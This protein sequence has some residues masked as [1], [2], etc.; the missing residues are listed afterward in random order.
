MSSQQNSFTKWIAVSVAILAVLGLASLWRWTP[1][2]EWASSGQLADDLEVL[3]RTPWAPLTLALVYLLATPL[4][5]PLTVLNLALIIAIG[6]VQGV[7]YALYG[8]LLAGLFAFWAGHL[9]GRPALARW[10]HARVNETLRVVRESGLPG[11]ILLRIVPLAPYPVINVILGAGGMRSLVFVAGT[12]LGVLPS[13]AVM[14]VLG[15]QLRSVLQ[16]P[17]PQGVTVL[18]ALAL[19]CL[20]LMVWVQ[21]R[22]SARLGRT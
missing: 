16:D 13:L 21:R 6:P 2:S 22:L 14:G 20:A 19:T 8:S 18:V 15:F 17:T 5:F 1:L 7:A 10:N 12:V 3:A 11:L 9:L 4:M